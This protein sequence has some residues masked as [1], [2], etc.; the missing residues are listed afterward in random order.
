MSHVNDKP[1]LTVS[2]SDALLI[3]AGSKTARSLIAR[4][5]VDFGTEVPAG[6]ARIAF[7]VGVPGWKRE[8]LLALAAS[9]D[10]SDVAWMGS[11]SG[12]DAPHLLAVH[13]GGEVVVV[14]LSTLAAVVSKIPF[15][16][17]TDAVAAYL[18]S[19]EQAGSGW[20]LLRL[21]EAREFA[22]RRRDGEYGAAFPAGYPAPENLSEGLESMLRP[23][24]LPM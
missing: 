5:G 22:M 3:L 16:L 18:H 19:A 6:D 14:Y 2:V 23:E 15:D 17:F 10:R 9:A 24:P 11:Q 1:V 13:A 7:E 12:T 20:S 21:E 4:A 8:D